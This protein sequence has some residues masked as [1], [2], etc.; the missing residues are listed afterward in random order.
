MASEGMYSIVIGG[1]WNK[2][3][4]TV[5]L[6]VRT[7]LQY[8]CYCNL[9]CLYV[10]GS[11]SRVA[12][13]VTITGVRCSTTVSHAHELVSVAASF[14]MSGR[15]CLVAVDVGVA[16]RWFPLCRWFCLECLLRSGQCEVVQKA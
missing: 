6:T 7:R 15:L 5:H 11:P 14:Q 13:R 3:F 9:H 4:S 16:L 10:G 8:C 2:V 12:S 1:S